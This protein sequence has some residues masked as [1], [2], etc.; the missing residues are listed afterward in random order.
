MRDRKTRSLTF[1]ALPPNYEATVSIGL[2]LFPIITAC[3]ILL[4]FYTHSR[5]EE[6]LKI[7]FDILSHGEPLVSAMA[8][9][10][11]PAVLI[12]VQDLVAPPKYVISLVGNMFV[13]IGLYCI[14]KTDELSTSDHRLNS[15]V[16]LIASL[17]VLAWSARL[18]YRSIVLRNEPLTTIV[19][20]AESQEN[21]LV[22]K[23][24]E[25]RKEENH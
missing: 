19:E 15:A 7:V 21:D 24:R 2:A 13:C 16:F 11:A 12:L 18:I 9:S 5:T 22:K 20:V 23:L 14:E 17:L 8:L 1:P 10:A 25:R 4:I 3:L 6:S